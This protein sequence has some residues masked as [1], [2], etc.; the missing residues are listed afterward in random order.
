MKTDEKILKTAQALLAS[1]GFGAVSFDTIGRSLGMSK[2]AVLY[3]YP[4]KK[5]LLAA[6]LG[7]WLAAEADVAVAAVD[8]K[9]TPN[10]AISAFVEAV[11]AFHL[12]DL[13][14]FRMMYLAPQTLKVGMQAP[15][16]TGTLDQV[17]ATTSR[18][19]CALADRLAGDPLYAR[20][21]AIS[22]HSAVL[23]LALMF[24]LADG[25]KDPLKHSQK[26]LIAALAARLTDPE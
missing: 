9:D 20:Q 4:S 15:L 3:W 10:A 14:R 2:Q 25:I 26:D 24:G 18:M 8:G 5:E 11:A 21:Q 23:G 6:M 7:S 12:G 22:I 17:H 13:D 1:D 19:Y 16:E